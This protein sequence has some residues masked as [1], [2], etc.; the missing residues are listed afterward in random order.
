MYDKHVQALNSKHL[1]KIRLL[2]S[3]IEEVQQV[4]AAMDHQSARRVAVESA[5]EEIM[6]YAQV[7]Q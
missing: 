7:Q 2:E 1:D 4:R 5:K 3:M 6:D